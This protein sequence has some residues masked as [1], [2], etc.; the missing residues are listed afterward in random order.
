MTVLW[1]TNYK[2]IQVTEH[3]RTG[4]LDPWILKA[5]PILDTLLSGAIHFKPPSGFLNDCLYM[6]MSRILIHLLFKER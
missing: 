5:L 4:H 1:H 2:A 6:L 3:T